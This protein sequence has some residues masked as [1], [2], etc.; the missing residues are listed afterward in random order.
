[1]Y[2]ALKGCHQTA[3]HWPATLGFENLV[4]KIALPVFSGSADGTK[5]AAKETQTKH[6]TYNNSFPIWRARVPRRRGSK[7]ARSGRKKNCINHKLSHAPQCS[8]SKKTQLP[9]KM[10][11]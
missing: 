5:L 9:K 3:C 11:K 7:E 10:Q 6:C 4:S 8:C 2:L 1:M